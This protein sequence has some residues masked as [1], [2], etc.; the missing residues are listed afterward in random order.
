VSV[1]NRPGPDPDEVLSYG[2]HPDQ[3]VDVWHGTGAVVVLLHGGFWRP[4]WDRTHLRSM[5]GA[6]RDAGWQV[7]LP[8][9]R[10][11]PG[12]PDLT[13]GD[14][15]AA[16]ELLPQPPVV[17]GH[18][19]GGHLA[20]WAA[21]QREPA[22][23][24]VLALAPVADLVLAEQLDL[25]GGAVR[26][27]LGGPAADRP[28]LDPNRVPANGV[29]VTVLHGTADD[30]VPLAVSASYAETHPEAR[31]VSLPGVDHFALIDPEAAVWPVLLD[32]LG[33]P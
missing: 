19:A 20:L 2:N 18:S 13:T 1:L 29:Q 31:R 24:G 4:D 9:Y 21:A 5:A 14:V 28:D 16:L 26:D 15:L 25:D 3:V 32:E 6:L 7:A 12:R 27:F 8:E 10:R 22:V 11:E 33:R 17:V 30:R 23:R